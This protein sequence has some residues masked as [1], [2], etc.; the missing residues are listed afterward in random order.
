V[1]TNL[2]KIVELINGR[3][4]WII[5]DE[6]AEIPRELQPFL[7]D[8]LRKTIFPIFGISIKIGAIEHRSCF[9]QSLPS[10]DYIGIEIGADVT[11][12]N[13]DEYMVFDNDE[14]TSTDFFRNLIYKHINPLLPEENKFLK[15]QQLISKT[16]TQ[17]GAFTEF[18]RATEGVPRDAINILINAAL[19]A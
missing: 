11:S 12:L 15:S 14:A 4:I 1:Q 18:V 7:A 16:F 8:L 13:L 19:N 2:S 9:R 6:W 10:T 3:E 17:S 5:I